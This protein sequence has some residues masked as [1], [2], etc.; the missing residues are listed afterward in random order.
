MGSYDRAEVCELIGIF[1]LSLIGNKY[2]PFN[3]GLYR[4]DRLVVK[5]S[6]GRQSGKIK[7]IFEKIFKNKGLDIIINCSMNIVNYLYAKLKLND[8]HYCIHLKT[9]TNVNSKKVTIFI[10]VKRNFWRNCVMQW[11]VPLKLAI[12]RK[13]E[14]SR[15]NTS[16]FNYKKE[17]TKKHFMV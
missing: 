16:K 14:L 7:K 1:I 5:N 11:T 10:I 4:D 12:Q 15:A 13:D 8:G 9:T 6:R 17:T 3:I 2:N